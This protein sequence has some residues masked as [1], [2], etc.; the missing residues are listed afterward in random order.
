[1]V[2]NNK[3]LRELEDHVLSDQPEEAFIHITDENE[4]QLLDRANA[5]RDRLYPEV[6]ELMDNE[7]ITFDEKVK[8]AQEIYGDLTQSEKAILDKDSEFCLLRLRDLLLK[9]FEPK[10]SKSCRQTVNTRILWFF[11]EMDK[12]LVSESII[13]SEFRLNRDEDSPDFDDFAW[14]DRVGAIIKTDFPEGVFTEESY[15]NLE[16]E[17]DRRHS[18]HIKQYWIAHPEEKES[19]FKELNKKLEIVKHATS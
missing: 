12:L 8:A 14:W 5:I 10:F 18:E 16:A 17:I 2:I 3:K 11:R 4:I 7:N 19:F 6:K 9:F 13:D 1:M 15:K